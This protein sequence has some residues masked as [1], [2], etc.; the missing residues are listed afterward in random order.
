MQSKRKFSSSIFFHLDF[1]FLLD[2][3]VFF[4]FFFLFPQKTNNI[5]KNLSGFGVVEKSLFLSFLKYKN[6]RRIKQIYLI[7]FGFGLLMIWLWMRLNASL[8]NQTE[9]RKKKKIKR[10]VHHTTPK[11]KCFYVYIFAFVSLQL[12]SESRKCVF[13]MLQ[14]RKGG[15]ILGVASHLSKNLP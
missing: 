14:H 1:P 2:F 13:I 3:L 7:V 4:L 5:K 15:F 10:N 9:R 11:S 8:N 12:K 6:M